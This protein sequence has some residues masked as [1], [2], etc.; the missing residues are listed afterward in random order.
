MDKLKELER[1]LDWLDT[2][3][4]A[5]DRTQQKWLLAIRNAAQAWLDL[6]TDDMVDDL[7]DLLLFFD[8]ADWDELP[9]SQQIAYEKKAAVLARSIAY[10]FSKDQ[11]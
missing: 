4:L 5:E 10:T 3:K 11:T 9:A 2:Y 7:M 1:A 6:P 8:D